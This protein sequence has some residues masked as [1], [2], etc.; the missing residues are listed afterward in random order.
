MQWM[1]G[2][3]SKPLHIFWFQNVKEFLIMQNHVCLNLVLCLVLFS[4]LFILSNFNAIVFVSLYLI[5]LLFRQKLFSFSNERQNR[6]KSRWKEVEEE[7]GGIGEGEAVIFMYYVRGN[8]VC[9]CSTHDL[10]L[11]DPIEVV[12]LICQETEKTTLS[13]R[14]K[15]CNRRQQ[16]TLLLLP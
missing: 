10:G 7:L 11:C 14:R 1:Y 8:V 2:S 16:L 12:I 15:E 13:L 3:E 4:S 5:L 6:S 9:F